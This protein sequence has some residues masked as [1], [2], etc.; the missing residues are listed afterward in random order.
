MLQSFIEGFLLGVGAALP[1]G[2]IN[3]LIMNNALKSYKAGVTLGLGA[4]SADILYLSL[5]LAGMIGFINNPYILSIIGILGS[6]FLLYLAYATY[7]NRA[8]TLEGQ[9][10]KIQIKNLIKTYTQGFI[11]TLFNPMTIIFWF[12]IAGYGVNRNLNMGFTIFGMISAITL[13]ITIMPYLI[14][15][16]KHKISQRVS[17]YLNI[18][19]SLILFGFAIFLFADVVFLKPL[20]F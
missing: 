4:M 19:S 1:L 6:I 9:T 10:K 15:R 20:I 18:I 8:K 16:S 5:I 13:W 12:S 14:H 2:P 11:L 3:I 7:K 17:K